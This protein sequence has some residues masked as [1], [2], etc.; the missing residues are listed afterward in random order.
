[1]REE[2]HVATSKCCLPET[3][4]TPQASSH[5]RSISK[6]RQLQPLAKSHLLLEKLTESSTDSVQ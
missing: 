4:P 2:Q 5:F 6:A 3:I 1:V